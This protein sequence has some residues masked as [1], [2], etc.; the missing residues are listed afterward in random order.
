VN[1]NLNIDEY[2]EKNYLRGEGR[3]ICGGVGY[4]H[5]PTYIG[6]SLAVDHFS[7]ETQCKVIIDQGTKAPGRLGALVS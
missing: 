6:S 3:D 5:T 7:V 2:T 4:A 1:R